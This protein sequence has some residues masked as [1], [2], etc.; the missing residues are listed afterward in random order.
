MTEEELR[1]R[2][3]QLLVFGFDGPTVPESME[4]LIRTHYLGNII[5]FSRNVD[6]KEQVV[7]LNDRLQALAR[8]SG[9]E[10]PLTI[11]AD[12]ENGIVRRLPTDLPGLPGNMALGAV[13]DESL[14]H[15]AGVVTGKLLAN[16]GINM[17][18]APVLD[19]NNNPA[20]P[21][22]GVRSFGDVADTVATL[23]GAFIDGLQSQGVIACGKHFPGHGDTHVDSHL[24]L[25]TI[26]HDRNRLDR[27]ELV[28]FRRAIEAGIDSIMTAHVV[29]PAIEPETIPATLSYRVLTELL[30]NELGFA[31]LITTDCM[32]MNAISE[33]IGVGLGAVAAL[34]AGADMI[35]VSHRLDRQ[36]EAMD[37]IVSA[38]KRGELAESRIEEA[39]ARVRALK[40]KRLGSPAERED[41][42]ALLETAHALQT[43]LAIKAVT[44][45]R[46]TDKVLPRLQ[47]LGRV[48]V[49][50]DDM[51]PL[52]VAAGRG[53]PNPLVQNAIK[54]VYPEVEVKDYVISS[55]FDQEDALLEELAGYDAVL[56]GVNGTRNTR[57]LHLVNRLFA[58]PIPQAALLLRSPYDA[59]AVHEAP[60]LWALYENT[61]WMARAAVKAVFGAPGEGHLPVAVSKTFP[62]GFSA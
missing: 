45:L 32:E 46:R 7:A 54:D 49:L 5:L 25:P 36:L 20:N 58:L 35:M 30:R 48:A 39:Y 22:I 19:V 2:V 27:V 15:T 29:F 47:S 31:G 26:G 59:T 40:L 8:E 51:T 28:P 38:V 3:G 11:S 62:R 9:Q 18:L 4:N 56:I 33:T 53:G 23:G 1:R 37:A 55:G 61:P 14:A 17:N 6:T 44:C 43:R 10:L 34:R 24:D 52:M 50:V 42:P 12:Q 57:Y 13:G 16:L 60:N 21:V 41:W